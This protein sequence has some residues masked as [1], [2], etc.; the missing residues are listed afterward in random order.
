MSKTPKDAPY[1]NVWDR[2]NTYVPHKPDVTPQEL[3][4]IQKTLYGTVLGM[5]V[6]GVD[7]LYIRGH[8]DLDFTA[9]GNPARYKY[10]PDGMLF[11]ESALSAPDALG[12]AVH[13]GIETVLMMKGLPYGNA[14]DLA[15]VFEWNLRQD[16]ASGRV[17]SPAT[18]QEAIALGDHWLRD[19]IEMIRRDIGPRKMTF[20][21]AEIPALKQR[22]QSVGYAYTTRVDAEQGRWKA[23]EIV[24]SPLGSL[25]IVAVKTLEDLARHPFLNELSPEQR[26]V[27]SKYNKLDVI[28]FMPS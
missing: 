19:K 6:W 9:G 2:M 26:A 7:G 27:L 14:H 12:V 25:R 5:Q 16:M 13:E 22:L 8:K 11:V 15:N 17:K 4:A 24:E 23:G 18:H 3:A 20:P 10:V 28:K 1:Y 21:A